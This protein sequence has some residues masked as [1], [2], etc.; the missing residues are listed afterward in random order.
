MVDH[1]VS[2]RVWRWWGRSSPR[3]DESLATTGT[4]GP[5]RSWDTA[6]NLTAKRCPSARITARG[7]VWLGGVLQS[8]TTPVRIRRDVYQGG[9]HCTGRRRPATG[10]PRPRRW[11]TDERTS[12]GSPDWSPQGGSDREH[13]SSAAQ[14]TALTRRLSGVRI[15]A[16]PRIT[17]AAGPDGQTPRPPYRP[18]VSGRLDIG[19]QRL[20]RA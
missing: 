12:V 4:T 2:S 6:A 9:H 16:R 8:R 13:R 7:R 18:S 15:P 17:V 5:A 1:A 3:L 20:V 11:P 19:S 14:D 10:R